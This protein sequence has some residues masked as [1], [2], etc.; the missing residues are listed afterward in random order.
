[1]KN[2]NFYNILIPNEIINDKDL[3]DFEKLLY[4]DI[5]VLAKKDGY[6]FASNKYF[7]KR[8]NKDIRTVQRA[9][10]NLE[11]KTHIVVC[12]DKV[13]RRIYIFSDY[14]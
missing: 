9:I 1:M 2:D 7:A 5:R 11:D 3:T 12:R 13:E 10:K 4:G 14:I 8:Y 6:C